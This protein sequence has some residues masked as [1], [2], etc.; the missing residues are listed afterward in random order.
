MLPV[1]GIVPIYD[2]T[3][4]S[5]TDLTRPHPPS[6]VLTPIQSVKLPAFPGRGSHHLSA[7]PQ[8]CLHPGGASRG[9]ES[10]NPTVTYG[11]CLVQNLD[12]F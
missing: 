6:P 11:I 1:D 9:T 2:P 4:I 5:S 7:N 12:M 8:T 10:P 3:S